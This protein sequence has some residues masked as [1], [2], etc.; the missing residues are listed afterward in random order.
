MLQRSTPH[1][2]SNQ[3]ANDILI[4]FCLHHSM[5]KII[6]LICNVFLLNGTPSLA[7]SKEITIINQL[8][9]VEANPKKGF[10]YPFY[11]YIPNLKPED[12]SRLLIIPN[13][14]GASDDSILFHDEAVMK[15]S[16]KWRDLSEATSSILLMPVFPRPRYQADKK[17]QALEYTHALDRDTLL[18]KN[19][20][21]KRLDL[22][23]IK[24]SDEARRIVKN[25]T[26]RILPKKFF[27][28]GFS[29]SAMFVNRFT[30]MH[31]ELVSAIAFGAPGGWPIAPAAQFQ[32]KDLRYPIGIFDLEKLTGKKVDFES[33]KKVPFYIFLG[34]KDE[35]DSVVYRDGYEVEDEDLIFSLFGKKPVDR[36]VI[37]EKL[38]KEAGLNA[39]YLLYEGI[40]HGTTKAINGDIIKFFN[41]IKDSS[42]TT[43][44]QHH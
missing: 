13:N 5:K 31:P 24:M 20:P 3:Y 16:L 26:S 17:T 38:Y 12:K 39:T 30:F 4:K 34:S 15:E 6:Y 18:V 33:L 32:E 10:N 2:V 27:L 36:W 23:L 37:A 29:A 14:S 22:Q 8:L 40:G 19:G 1:F 41:E 43:G 11:I 42:P 21:L 7:L 35:N 9:R 25:K 28:F 44:K